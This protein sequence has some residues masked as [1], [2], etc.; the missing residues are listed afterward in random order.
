[1]HRIAIA[2]CLDQPALTP[3]DELLGPALA[4]AGIS[5]TAVPWNEKGVEWTRF[6]GI[7]IRSTWDYY[8][9]LG[10]FLDWIDRIAA[11]GSRS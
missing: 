10:A 8:Q 4:S 5:W 11:A 6:D 2:T 7:L 3:D 9:H 1:M